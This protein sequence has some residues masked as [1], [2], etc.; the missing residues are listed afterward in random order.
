MWELCAHTVNLCAK[1]AKPEN[2]NDPQKRS[3]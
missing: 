1:T 2:L 3:N